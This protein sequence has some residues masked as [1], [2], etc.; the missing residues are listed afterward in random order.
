MKL[1]FII[2]T[3]SRDVE[4]RSMLYSLIAQTDKEWIA[5][6]IIDTPDESPA[7]GIIDN[8]GDERIRKTHM[9]KRYN[10]WGH[11]L[12]E[13]GKQ[14]SDSDYLLMSGD[15]NYYM[16]IFTSELKKSII[17][18][19]GMV[20]WDMVHS[21]YNYHYFKCSPAY[22]QIDMGAFATRTNLAKQIPIGTTFAADGLFIED[23]KKK[24]PNEKIVKIDKVLFIHN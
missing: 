5:H 13:Y 2:P 19:P 10:D 8:I 11:S 9:D 22:N 7:D 14:M 20:Y 6:V 23:F 1:E 15:D 3:F 24:F 17:N 21:H 4:L 16:P 18:N 12:R